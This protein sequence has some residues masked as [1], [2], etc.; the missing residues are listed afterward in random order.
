MKKKNNIR[1]FSQERPLIYKERR[2]KSATLQ[3]CKPIVEYVVLVDEKEGESTGRL[4]E[5]G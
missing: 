5:R 3:I 1:R 2:E 4:E